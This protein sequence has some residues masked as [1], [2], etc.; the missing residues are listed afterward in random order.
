MAMENI[1]KAFKEKFPGVILQANRIARQN[2]FGKATAVEFGIE[3][4]V[5]SHT[6][7]GYRKYTTGEYV[8]NKYLA[9]FG[10]KNTYYQHAETIVQIKS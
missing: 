7:Y 3:D 4:K 6:C 10:W 2:G 5:I 1:T 8:P 9:N